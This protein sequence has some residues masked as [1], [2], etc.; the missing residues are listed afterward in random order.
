[1]NQN[2]FKASIITNRG[3]D[4]SEKTDTISLSKLTEEFQY[5]VKFPFSAN[6]DTFH[7]SLMF[8]SSVNW[9]YLFH[10]DWVQ[11]DKVFIKTV[12]KMSDSLIH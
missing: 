12:C 1:M 9:H 8:L 6:F 5:K 10:P 7:Q 11:D 2:Q 3:Y 4:F